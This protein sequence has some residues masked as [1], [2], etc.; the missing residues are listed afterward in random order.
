MF[1]PW[2]DTVRGETGF[3]VLACCFFFCFLLA[4]LGRLAGT[5]VS[6]LAGAPCP[7]LTPRACTR[8]A[9]PQPQPQPSNCLSAPPRTD[10]IWP[11]CQATL[12][13]QRRPHSLCPA[14]HQPWAVSP[15]TASTMALLPRPV[16]HTPG[17]VSPCQSWFPDS[18][19]L[20]SPACQTYSSVPWTGVSACL[21]TVDQLGSGPPLKLPFRPMGCNHASP[22]IRVLNSE[23]R[24]TAKLVLPWKHSLS[25]RV[26]LSVL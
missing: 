2:R 3:L 7:S 21:A 4:S 26:F 15:R 23:S 19:S 14:A 25:R 13:A 1:S 16:L 22:L 18:E 5:H 24:P 20:L 12:L 11:S 17:C 9:S 8:S 6:V 10:P